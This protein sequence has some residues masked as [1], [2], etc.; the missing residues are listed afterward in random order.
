MTRLWDRTPLARRMLLCLFAAILLAALP[1]CQTQGPPTGLQVW[2]KGW[3]GAPSAETSES[4]QLE[5]ETIECGVDP[6]GDLVFSTNTAKK[7]IQFPDGATI[8]ADTFKV[9]LQRAKGAETYGV[10]PYVLQAK[11]GGEVRLK[12]PFPPIVQAWLGE[13]AETGETVS[14][15]IPNHKGPLIV[16]CPIHLVAVWATGRALIFGTTA[17]PEEKTPGSVGTKPPDEG[18]KPPD[19]GTTPPDE[20]TKPPEGGTNPEG[21]GTPGGEGGGTGEPNK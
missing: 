7:G 20:G 11:M 1:A 18:T 6:N 21:G 3:P 16:R 13:S 9:V 19:E 10:G 2:Q 8:Q 4:F 12:G 15:E 17:K 14:T 5:A